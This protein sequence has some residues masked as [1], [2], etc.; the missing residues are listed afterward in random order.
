LRINDAD[1]GLYTGNISFL[2]NTTRSVV[3]E[4]NVATIIPG[5]PVAPSIFRMALRSQGNVAII[6]M[7]DCG[8]FPA[9]ITVPVTMAGAQPGFSSASIHQGSITLTALGG[10]TLNWSLEFINTEFTNQGANFATDCR[11]TLQ[12]LSASG[13]EQIINASINATRIDL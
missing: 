13:S 4:Q 3:N 10:R 2:A 11:I 9:Q 6:E 12:G 8:I 5:A 1:R 7:P